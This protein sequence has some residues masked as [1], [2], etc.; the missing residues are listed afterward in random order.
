MRVVITIILLTLI[1]FSCKETPIDDEYKRAIEKYRKEKDSL[2]IYDENSPFKRDTTMK[3]TG[4]KY[5]DIN[6]DF[7]FK[8]KLYKYAIPE[9]VIVLGT[10]GEERLQIK[11]GFFQFTYKGQSYKINAYKYPD[12]SIKDG[13]EYLRNYL[14]V[15][16]RDLTTGDETYEV[17]RYLEIEPESP[18]PDYLYT[19]DF[20]KAYNPYC[21]Y[22]PLYSC[23]IPREED[24]IRLR[25]TAG[26]KKYHQK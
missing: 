18:D 11:Y 5:F 23:A 10:K 26:E 22:T 25:V 3:F 24:F 15:W 14:A 19:L 13:K 6:P 21:A 17:G 2:F 12:A 16:F 20:N 4:L 7:V 8:S 9:T 1:L